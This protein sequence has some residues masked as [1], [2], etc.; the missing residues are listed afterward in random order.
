MAALFRIGIGRLAFEQSTTLPKVAALHCVKCLPSFCEGE[1]AINGDIDAAPARPCVDPCSN[2][3]GSLREAA[4]VRQYKP[5]EG[6]NLH[7]PSAARPN[8]K[9]GSGLQSER[10]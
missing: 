3:S 4:P 2:R 1:G 9:A 5:N 6:E 7:Q 8:L 10:V